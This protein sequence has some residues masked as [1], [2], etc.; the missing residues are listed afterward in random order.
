[1]QEV[2]SRGRTYIPLNGNRVRNAAFHLY[3]EMQYA[4]ALAGLTRHRFSLTDD[5]YDE[6][7]DIAWVLRSD[8]ANQIGYYYIYHL[9]LRYL[10]RDYEGALMQANLVIPTL[11]AFS[12][13]FVE[14]EYVLFHALA[15]IARAAEVDGAE[16]PAMLEAAMAHRAR[17]EGWAA[18]CPANF[19]HQLGLL[20]A[21]IS[22]SEGSDAHAQF[23]AAAEAAERH[24]F[25]QH[26]GLAHERAAIAATAQGDSA[27]AANAY[28]RARDHYLAWGAHAKVADVEE[29]AAS[30][31]SPVRARPRSPSPAAQQHRGRRELDSERR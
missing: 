19:D 5:E 14:S 3:H 17:L 2:I 29:Q 31:V 23:V 6:E 18:D 1:M 13:Q 22:R 21:E 7:S 12:G 25:V 30:L 8:L 9:R 15:L 26:A 4:K 28:S 20:D 24:G 11:P 16:R 27:R 10:Y